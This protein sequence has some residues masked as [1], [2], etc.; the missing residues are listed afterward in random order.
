MGALRLGGPK[1]IQWCTIV[2]GI[3]EVFEGLEVGLVARRV[4]AKCAAKAARPAL[5]QARIGKEKGAERIPADVIGD[6]VGGSVGLGVLASPA[7]R[8]ETA[9]CR[10]RPCSPKR[11]RAAKAFRGLWQRCRERG[12]SK[13][14]KQRK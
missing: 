9:R 8:T 4:C 1:N 7:A 5:R 14:S 10:A 6:E 13:E 12:R 11:G 2:T 3:S